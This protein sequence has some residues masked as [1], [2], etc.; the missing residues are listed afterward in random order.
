LASPDLIHLTE[1]GAAYMGDR[2]V[3]AMHVGLRKYIESHPRAGCEDDGPPR[4][5]PGPRA[6][7]KALGEPATRGSAPW[8]PP[9]VSPGP[10]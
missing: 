3:Y 1:K 7:L 2:L 6:L 10:P 9:G 4:P 5:E 8:T